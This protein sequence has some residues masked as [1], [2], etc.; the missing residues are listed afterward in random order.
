MENKRRKIEEIWPGEKIT[1]KEAFKRI[2]VT[3][4]TT[5]SMVFLASS[6]SGAKKSKPKAP[7][8]P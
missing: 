6:A 4:L 8:R 3:A 5:A 7:G 1:R 2:G